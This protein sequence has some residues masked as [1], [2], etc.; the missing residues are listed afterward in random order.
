MRC[1][2]ME[3]MALRG[4]IMKNTVI[5]TVTPKACDSRDNGNK[6]NVTT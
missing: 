2:I 6:S 4:D 5:T 3:S 1:N